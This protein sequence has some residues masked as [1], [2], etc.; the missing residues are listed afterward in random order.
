M[1]TRIPATKAKPSAGPPAHERRPGSAGRAVLRIALH[2]VRRVA[3]AFKGRSTLLALAACAVVLAAV[4]PFILQRG[5]QPDRGLYPVTIEAGSPLAAAARSDARFAE[6]PGGFANGAVL[7]LQADRVVWD[8]RNPASVA[9]FHALQEAL[10][11]WQET[12]LGKERDQAAAFPVQVDLVLAPR[13]PAPAT[14][15]ATTSSAPPPS[16]PGT[17]GPATPSIL[18]A[19]APKAASARQ[20]LHPADVDPPFPV[21]SLLLTFAYLIPLNFV[22]QLHAGTLLSD[23]I[24]KRGLLA[25]TTPHAPR[26]ILLGRSLPYLALG[27]AVL[28]FGSVAARAGWLGWLAAVPIVLFVLSSSL[29]LG[30]LARNERE[31]TF[32]LTGAT[33]MTSV[34]LFLP[35]VFTAV[36]AVAF[37][38]PV[39]VLV[40]SIQGQAVGVGPF[41]YATLPLTLCTLAFALV[42]I[43]LYREETLFTPRRVRDTLLAGLAVRA[44][45]GWRTLA[46]GA[47]T[48]PFAFALELLVLSLAI[49]LGLSVALPAIL[50][51]VAFVEERLKLA[52]SAAGRRA[53]AN[54]MGAAA[55]AGAGFFVGEKLAVVLAIVGFGDLRL[56]D[57]TLRTFGVSGGWLLAIAPLA[58]HVAAAMVA[59]SGLGRRP[60]GTVA[61][62]A[63]VALH[64]GYDLAVAGVA[65]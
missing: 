50:L 49:P 9:G 48:V 58:L 26:T 21:R 59:A 47:L 34:F 11:K 61:Y 6:V 40:A 1:A 8:E 30:L 36:P 2:E 28:A 4:G 46:C 24:R 65:L 44:R 16:T 12:E 43:A 63:A 62:L 38:S 27:A 55:W 7:D 60:W 17:A 15:T 31:L 22:A 19:E 14:A 32:L 10:T 56:G 64:F 41:L 3:G 5:V 57:A 51:G 29:L 23:R 18:Q 45:T 25:L 54:A 13:A 52:V 53:G 37:L 35:A 20:G 42:G 39:S 33:T